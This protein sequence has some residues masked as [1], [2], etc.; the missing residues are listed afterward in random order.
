MAMVAR[1]VGD[2]GWVFAVG[3]IEWWG[4][5]KRDRRML[6]N[7]FVA[8]YESVLE[9]RKGESAI[10]QKLKVRVAMRAVV[11]A[12]SVEWWCGRDF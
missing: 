10:F 12:S 4:K 11:E 5:R 9:C 7:S 1:K 3:R 6:N 8:A 2:P